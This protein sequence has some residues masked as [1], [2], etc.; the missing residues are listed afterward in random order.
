MTGGKCGSTSIDRNFH[1]L[2]G[3]RFGE[4]F[5]TLSIAKKGPGSK[6]MREFEGIKKDFSL[7]SYET[8][9]ISLKMPGLD[10]Q[11]MDPSIYDGEDINLSRS[12]CI[13]YP[14]SYLVR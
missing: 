4:A 9:S 11:G 13:N 1:V 2:M 7:N 3:H 8:H 10:G 5:S 12:M 6:F 14:P